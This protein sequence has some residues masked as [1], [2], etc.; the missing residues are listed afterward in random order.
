MKCLLLDLIWSTYSQYKSNLRKKNLSTYQCL[1]CSLNWPKFLQCSMV[2][3]FYYNK[4]AC[5]VLL[6]KRFG[7]IS[8]KKVTTKKEYVIVLKTNKS[9][10][11]RNVKEGFK[12][13]LDLSIYIRKKIMTL[14]IDV[15]I[16]VS[17]RRKKRASL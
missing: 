7:A 12:E 15:P 17:C 13:V 5:L 16:V 9:K 2:W 6:N 10:K 14:S 1:Q 8:Q 4:G 11:S 3:G